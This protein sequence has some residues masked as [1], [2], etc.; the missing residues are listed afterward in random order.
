MIIALQH[1]DNSIEASKLS[2]YCS[3][4]NIPIVR[5]KE[6][7][8]FLGEYTPC[9]SVEWCQSLLNKTIIPDYYPE[10]LRK[11]LYR[12]VWKSNEW[13]FGKKLFVKP[14]DRYKRFD[15]YTTDSTFLKYSAKYYDPPFWYSEIIEVTNEWRYYIADGKILC[16]KWYMGDE[17]G[18]PPAPK[19]NIDIPAGY[20]G[21]IDFGTNAIGTL[22]LIEAQ[23]PFSCGWYGVGLEDIELYIQWL[24][25]GWKYMLAL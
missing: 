13:I 8:P 24:E 10:W 6:N 14:A 3:L 9:G 12:N 11:Y 17:I 20:C 5:I 21:A 25:A 1:T 19:L 22:I 16:G 4:K 15:G 18:T 7:T 2:L 23:H